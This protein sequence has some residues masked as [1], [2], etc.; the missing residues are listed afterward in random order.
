MLHQRGLPMSR[1]VTLIVVAVFL[2]TPAACQNPNAILMESL[3][4][5]WALIEPYA[6]AGIEA[7]EDL[8]PESKENRLRLVQ[9]FTRTLGEAL[10][11]AE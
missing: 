11:H 6:V 5:S 4:K 3:N 9:D 7:D 8:S 10:S 2:L 1:A